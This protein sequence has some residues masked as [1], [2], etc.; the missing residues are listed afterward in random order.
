MVCGVQTNPGELFLLR[1]FDVV[2]SEK[3]KNIVRKPSDDVKRKKEREER[4]RLAGC[5]GNEMISNMRVQLIKY[6]RCL[7]DVEK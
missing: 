2:G 3:T 1:E 5:R 6:E 4:S 7:F